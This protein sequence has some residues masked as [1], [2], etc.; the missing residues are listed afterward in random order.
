MFEIDGQFLRGAAKRRDDRA[1]QD[2][3]PDRSERVL[4]PYEKG[5][6]GPVPHA[7]QRRQHLGEHAATLR[8]RGADLGLI[9][10]K[11]GHPLLGLLDLV[12]QRLHPLAGADQGLVERR[13][14]LVERRNLGP[15]LI[16]TL[17]RQRYI[18]A[19]RIEFGLPRLARLWRKRRSILL[20]SRRLRVSLS[21]ADARDQSESGGLQD[22]IVDQNGSNEIQISPVRLKRGAT[23]RR[24]LQQFP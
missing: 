8:E 18:A 19:Y 4:R 15:Q 9:V 12:L 13:I 23:D 7:L 24:S 6:R 16:L 10:G 11:G 21:G 2:G 14:V 20:G 5:G 22:D 1:E 3:A 17:L